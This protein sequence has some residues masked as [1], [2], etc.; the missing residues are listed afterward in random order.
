MVKRVNVANKLTA[1][2]KKA[3]AAQKREAP[4]AK[5]VEDKS[6]EDSNEEEAP[7]PGVKKATPA[8]A[9]SVKNGSVTKKSRKW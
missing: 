7:P 4:Q 2:K 9:A 8:K 3:P 6:S 5:E 1:Q